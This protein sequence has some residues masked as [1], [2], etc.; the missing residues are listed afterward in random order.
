M[1]QYT[2]EQVAQ[3]APD[4]ASAQA[5]RGLARPDKWQSLQRNGAMLWGLCKGSGKEPYRTQCDLSAPAWRCTCPS[6]KFPCKHGL[7]L[8]FMFA[9]QESVFSE[10]AL[11]DWVQAWQDARAQRSAAKQQQSTSVAE[12]AQA[13]ARAAQRAQ[14]RN[15]EVDAGLQ[16]F[17]RWLQD[18]MRNG[19]IVARSQPYAYWDQAA[20]RLVDAKAGALARRVRS[21]P[22]AFAGDDWQQRALFELGLL[23]LIIQAWGQSADLPP[24]LQEDVRG[25]L[26]WS[27]EQARL[28]QQQGVAG[29]WLALGWRVVEE[30]DLAQRRCW[31]HDLDSGRMALLLDFSPLRMPFASAAPL[32]GVL[33]EGEIVYYA[34]HWPQRALWRGAAPAPGQAWRGQL[35][36]VLHDIEQLLAAHAQ[37]LAQL[38]WL[39]RACYLLNDVYAARA[40][41]GW[42]ICDAQG[43]ALP[44]ASASSDALWR[45]LALSGG[46]ALCLALEWDGQSLY[47]LGLAHDAA[48]RSLSPLEW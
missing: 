9:A 23:Q 38:P 47:L 17:S 3:F 34:S 25:A 35:T 45:V 30:D 28:Q 31:L 21:L 18:L 37:A 12:Q 43:R 4:A 41:S 15:Q 19:L 44:L 27:Q 40:E 5:G 24:A 46:A 11:P 39:E 7:A 32:P 22:R 42:M 1:P 29:R 33:H 20:A 6:R 16:E 26:G 2:S 14:Q 13:A 10:A 48:W 8:L 36:H